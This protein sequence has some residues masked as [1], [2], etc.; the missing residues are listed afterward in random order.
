RRSPRGTRARSR[1]VE[2]SFRKRSCSTKGK[3]DPEKWKPVF[4]KDHAPLKTAS[5][6]VLQQPL[7]IIELELRPIRIAEPAAQLLEHAPRALHVDF[8]RHFHG[9]VVAIFA[10]AHRTAQ[11]IGALGGARLVAHWLAHAVAHAALHRFGEALRAFAETL[12]G[13]ALGIDGTFGVAALQRT[14][15][16]LHGLAR[17]P[18]R[19]VG[20][21]TGAV[22]FRPVAVLTVAPQLLEHLFELLAQALLVL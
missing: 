9:E 12:Q 20:V 8:A 13:A 10:R 6:K 16:V 19:L 15:G 14:F 17:L 5:E 3:H 7:Q 21:L 11:G 1:K 18:Q 4:G 22:I 2:T